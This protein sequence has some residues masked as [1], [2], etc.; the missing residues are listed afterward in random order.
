MPANPS[1]CHERRRVLLEAVADIAGYSLDFRFLN[2]KRPDVLRLHL[3]RSGIFLGEAKHTEQPSNLD[4]TDRLRI[5]FDSVLQLAQNDLKC[6]IAV[7]HRPALTK[8]WLNRL[9][10]LCHDTPMHSLSTSTTISA[11]TSVTFL[12][13]GIGAGFYVRRDIAMPKCIART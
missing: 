1:D 9:N 4:S 13:V 11:N 7:A 12:T 6:I 2:G 3:N 8:S 10:W 5:Y